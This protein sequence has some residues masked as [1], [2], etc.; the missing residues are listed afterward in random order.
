[1]RNIRV[2][3][4]QLQHAPG[5]KAANLAAIERFASQ[6]AAKR[7]QIIA[8]P[9]CCI[10]GYWHLRKLTRPQMEALAER[11]PDG[12]AAQRLLA[13]SKQH[14][15]TI[16]AG[17]LEIDSSGKLFNS[18]FVAMPDG[19]WAWFTI[20]MS[21]T[22]VCSPSPTTCPGVRRV[23]ATSSPLTTSSR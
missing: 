8:F 12:A 15:M 20:S 3:A 2:A 18:F 16:G 6:A 23:A 11:V 7:A 13:L 21:C 1:M 9:E 4:V 19:R 17:L 22:I 14:G 5:D 10:S